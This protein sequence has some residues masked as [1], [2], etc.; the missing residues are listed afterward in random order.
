MDQELK[1]A[2]CKMELIEKGRQFSAFRYDLDN[3]IYILSRD[4]AVIEI[5]SQMI[6]SESG[7]LKSGKET[8]FKVSYFNGFTKYLNMIASIKGDSELKEVVGYLAKI[9]LD[10]GIDEQFISFEDLPY[11]FKRNDEVMFRH[12]DTIQAARISK[13]RYED[14]M[15]GRICV[16]SCKSFTIINGTASEFFITI[17]VPEFKSALPPENLPLKRLTEEARSKLI[18]KN[19]KAL[20]ILK[21]SSFLQVTGDCDSIGVWSIDSKYVSGRVM[22]DPL[23]CYQSDSNVYESLTRSFKGLKN[24]KE[25][26]HIELEPNDLVFLN[27]CVIGYSLSLKEWIL[28]PLNQCSIIKFK[29]DAFEKMEAPENEKKILLAL[30]QNDSLFTDIIDEKGGGTIVLLAGDPGLGK[31]LTAEALAEKLE[32][33]L[34]KVS[35]AELGLNANELELSLK[36]IITITERWKAILLID[37]A[38]VF[39][40]ERSVS[41]IYRNAM[42]AVFLRLLEY[43]S[44]FMFLTSNRALNIDPAFFSRLT[45]AIQV[46]DYDGKKQKIWTSLLN[47]ANISFDEDELIK[48]YQYQV[49]GR[50]IK[51]SIIS[52]LKIAASEKRRVELGDIKLFLDMNITFTKNN[53]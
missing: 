25:K 2:N 36:K 28:F 19:Q 33:P 26:S 22:I 14:S 1:T 41:D 6:Q 48:L 9:N 21:S 12:E 18:K 51:T 47:E 30:A 44:G 53:I 23:S 49:N 15:S 45:L 29:S 50:Q 24:P 4:S 27:L 42:V 3:E 31:T 16:I 10:L 20:D 8:Y 32:R 13:V 40:E 43:Y 35:I 39:M 34:Y 37:E 46:Q 52:A 38:D 17:V 11:Y 5:M 7:Y